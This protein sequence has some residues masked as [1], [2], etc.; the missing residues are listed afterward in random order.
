M[1]R[2]ASA[3]ARAGFVRVV[4]RLR[5]QRDVD[6][7]VLDRQLLELARFQI[8]FDD[9][10]APRQRLGARRARRPSDRRRSTRDAQRAA[11]IVR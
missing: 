2:A 7:R 3:T 9:A 10:A 5:Q 6:R 1:I 4:Q 11:S 8:T